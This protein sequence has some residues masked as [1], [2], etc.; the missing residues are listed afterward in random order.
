[1]T[2]IT[3]DASNVFLPS[4]RGRLTEGVTYDA[5]NNTLLWIDI[6]AGEVHRVGLDLQGFAIVDTHVTI[7]FMDETESVGAIALTKNC[8]KVLVCGKRG[9]AIGDFLTLSIT[10]FLRYPSN[11]RLRSNDGIIDPWG[12]LWIGL[13]T[14]FS[15]SDCEN[16]PLAEGVLYRIDC[17]LL[18]ITTML[19]GTTISNGLGFASDGTFYW[20][21]SKTYTIWKF[22]YDQNTKALTNKREFANLAKLMKDS[23]PESPPEPDGL[24]LTTDGYVYTAAFGTGTVVVIACDSGDIV[25]QFSVPA[26]RVTCVAFGGP[27]A[28]NLYV[29][30]GHLRLEESDESKRDA[31]T[32][33]DL[34]GHLFVYRCRSSLNGN[35]SYIWGGPI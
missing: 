9:V 25:K 1:M 7:A 18:E 32:G 30:S 24:R 13:M 21:D 27:E 28:A 5:R 14:D 8:D 35:P 6:I 19:Q 3:L 31:Y 2:Q 20:T 26:E 10:Y 23:D 12:N 11:P 22:D 17:V 16:G 4:Y 34:G 15:Q 29:T 33:D